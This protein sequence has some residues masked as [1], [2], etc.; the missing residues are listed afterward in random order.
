MD[1]LKSVSFGK[2][3]FEIACTLRESMLV[4]GLLT[5]CEVWHDLKD[6]E[7][8]KLEEVDRLLLRRILQ[9]AVSCPIEALYLE[10]GCI[11][12]GII[13]KSRR[14]NYLHHLVTR[15]ET[16]ILWKIFITQWNYPSIR[17]EWTDQ[18]K[19]D[20]ESFGIPNELDWIKVKS[21]WSFKA[22]VK[23]QARE[24]AI[25]TL[26]DKKETHSKMEDLEYSE[27]LM[28]K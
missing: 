2:H 9:V 13:I 25:E 21:K 7:V 14:I 24:I 8:N 16:E 26:I 12:L 22:L 23:K 3:Y 19:R 17:G 1:L 5:N 4:N 18:V 28:Q 15:K 6:T 27:L 20:L 11:P 10:L